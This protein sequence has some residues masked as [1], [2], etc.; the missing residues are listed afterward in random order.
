[1]SGAF[2]I[3]VRPRS[4]HDPIV[5]RELEGHK[6]GRVHPVIN[7]L[8]RGRR[9]A[10]VRLDPSCRVVTARAD[11]VD[12]FRSGGEI[13]DGILPILEVVDDECLGE[14]TVQVNRGLR[15]V[16]EEHRYVGHSGLADRRR[17]ATAVPA[18][19]VVLPANQFAPGA[20][21]TREPALGH[22]RPINQYSPRPRIARVLPSCETAAAGPLAAR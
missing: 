16:L 18:L 21:R 5:H 22:P 3:P 17:Q 10:V 20:S 11:H 19:A 6:L 13:A 12:R 9:Q 8:H 4:N 2:S 14:L 1:M 7:R 15:I